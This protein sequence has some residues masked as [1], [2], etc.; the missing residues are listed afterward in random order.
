MILIPTCSGHF[1]LP[2]Y[3]QCSMSFLK[4]VLAN[5][6]RLFK[7]FEAPVVD[8]PPLKELT[9]K[10]VLELALADEVIQQYLPDKEDIGDDYLD[11]KFLFAVVNTIEPTFFERCLREYQEKNQ[12]KVVVENPQVD[13][14]EEMLEVLDNYIKSSWKRKPVKSTKASLSKLRTDKEKKKRNKEAEK[15]KRDQGKIQLTTK[16]STKKRDYEEV[17]GERL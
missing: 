5:K 4:D 8:F 10:Q 2:P 13:I 17:F 15:A 6:K 1:L 7:V 12:A 9:V 14:T 3:R 16:L 11:R